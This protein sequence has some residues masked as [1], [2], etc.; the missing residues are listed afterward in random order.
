MSAQ[1]PDVRFAKCQEEKGLQAR[2]I[3]EL[4]LCRVI[5]GVS[6]GAQVLS[7]DTDFPTLNNLGHKSKNLGNMDYSFFSFQ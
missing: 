4:C 2:M 7:K 6:L 3:K 5:H 1:E